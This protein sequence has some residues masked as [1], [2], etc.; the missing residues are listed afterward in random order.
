MKHNMKQIIVNIRPISYCMKFIGFIAIMM[1]LIVSCDE[2]KV[3][4]YPI[5]GIPPGSITGVQVEALPGGAKISYDFPEET[6]ISYV[7]CEYEFEG[8]QKIVRSSVYN[9]FVTVEGLGEIAPCKFTLYLVDHSEN[10]SK[11]YSGEFTPLEPPYRSIFNTITMEPDF[12]GVL[13]RWENET[14]TLIGAFLYAMNDENEWEEYDLIF[15]TLKD[16]KRSIRGYNTDER[17]FGVSLVDQFGNRTDTVISLETPLYEEELNKDN[18]ANGHLLGDN[19]TTHTNNRSIDKIWDEDLDFIWHSSPTAGFTPPQTFTI[20]LGVEALLSRL[21]VWNRLDGFYFGQHN[22]HYFEVWGA[23]ELS[24]DAND[25]YWAGEE[26]KDEWTLLGD[27]EQIKPSGLPLGQHNDEDIAATNAGSE[28]VFE[29]G[30]GEMRYLRF[31]VK[32]TWART[33]A[34]HIAEVSVFGDDGIVNEGQE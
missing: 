26:W 4:Q 1:T 9:N 21:V 8:E 11:P 30:V 10:R 31:V 18:F 27:F 17:Q 19:Y 2:E 13:I 22:L 32:E 14:N 23:R 7:I 24:H 33:A 20:D 28:F 25:T 34:I 3:G 15:S 29:P 6:D 16:E 5:D 12:G